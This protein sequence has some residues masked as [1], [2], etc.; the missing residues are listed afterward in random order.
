MTS[1]LMVN[2]LVI[3]ALLVLASPPCRAYVIE[4]PDHQF[5]IDRRSPDVAVKRHQLPPVFKLYEPV[6]RPEQVV[7]RDVLLEPELIEQ[8]SL[9]DLRLADVPS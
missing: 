2:S 5:R 3:L 4:H 6:D 7:G 1:I 8:R 9:F